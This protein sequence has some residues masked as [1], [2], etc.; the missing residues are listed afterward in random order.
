VL[1]ISSKYVAVTVPVAAMVENDRV[2][3]VLVLL[4][5]LVAFCT[6]LGVTTAAAEILAGELIAALLATFARAVYVPKPLLLVAVA[7]ILDMPETLD[8]LRNSTTPV[9]LPVP[10]KLVMAA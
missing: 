6:T 9:T 1:V 8:L 7:V 4:S 10:D 2:V 3:I 5:V